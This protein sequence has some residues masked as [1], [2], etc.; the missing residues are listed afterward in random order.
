M[1][2]RD[3]SVPLRHMRDAAKRAAEIAGSLSRE[4][5]DA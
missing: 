1:S 4:C 2:E 3:P 5:V